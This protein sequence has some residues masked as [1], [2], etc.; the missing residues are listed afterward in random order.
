MTDVYAETSTSGTYTFVHACG[1]WPAWTR[2]DELRH[3]VRRALG[4]LG[5]GAMFGSMGLLMWLLE[6]L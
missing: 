6:R 2:D 5:I 1:I 3:N 4:I